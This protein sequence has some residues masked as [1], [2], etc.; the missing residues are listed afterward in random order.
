MINDY[1]E[2]SVA[3][4]ITNDIAIYI[5]KQLHES[6]SYPNR[7]KHRELVIKQLQNE[8]YINLISLKNKGT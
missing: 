8:C 4:H 3:H 7:D 5:P 6:C 2:D 1:F